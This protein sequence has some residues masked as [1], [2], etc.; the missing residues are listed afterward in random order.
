M[1]V[2]DYD[3]QIVV[4]VNDDPAWQQLRQHA[5]ADGR[6]LGLKVKSER[7]M[8]FFADRGASVAR[9]ELAFVEMEG[10]SST[11]TIAEIARDVFAA[12]LTTVYTTRGNKIIRLSSTSMTPRQT[13]RPRR[14]KRLDA[15][16]PATGY[17]NG[18]S[19]ARRE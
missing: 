11:E 3:V 19:F 18:W 5:D 13:P 12:G 16:T 9:N 10:R 14:P 2:D 8:K 7:A 17:D 1:R 6:I 4:I 15:D